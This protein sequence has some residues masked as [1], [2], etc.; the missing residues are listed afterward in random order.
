MILKAHKTK[1]QKKIKQSVCG[2]AKTPDLHSRTRAQRPLID[3]DTAILL[4]NRGGER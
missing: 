2:T 1:R 4:F 3:S